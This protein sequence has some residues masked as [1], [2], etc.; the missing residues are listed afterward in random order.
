MT[1]RY[2]KNPEFIKL[3]H[4]TNHFLRKQLICRMLQCNDWFKLVSLLYSDLIT[5]ISLHTKYTKRHVGMY[6]N[7][8]TACLSVC[9]CY[10]FL[11]YENRS[12]IHDG[13]RLFHILYNK[14][15]RYSGLKYSV[16]CGLPIA[17]SCGHKILP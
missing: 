1:F 13:K 6:I 4:Q 7:L 11:H 15:Y 8:M 14:I 3:V 5:L 17:K 9:V 16:D 2:K 10:Y 12:R